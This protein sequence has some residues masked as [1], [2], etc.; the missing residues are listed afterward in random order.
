MLF[1][2]NNNIHVILRQVYVENSNQN[3]IFY[4]QNNYMVEIEDIFI[5]QSNYLNIFQVILGNSL[6]INNIQIS[7]GQNSRILQIL[8]T[9]DVNIQKIQ[10]NES[11]LI[12][13]IEINS[14]YI[15]NQKFLQ[16]QNEIRNLKI[17]NS[18]DVFLQ[19]DCGASSIYD[20]QFIQLNY[21]LNYCISLRT[22][23]LIMDNITVKNSQ[24]NSPGFI[25]IFMFNNCKIQNIYS[26][27]ND[28]QFI[29]LM[30]QNQGGFAYILNSK[31]INCNLQ[32][33]DYLIYL[34]SLD[35]IF[36]DQIQIKDNLFN[37]T[38]RSSALLIME[39]Q[40]ITLTNFQVKNNTNMMGAGGSIYVF[41]S[42]NITIKNSIFI[43]NKC[44]YFQGGALFISSS[45]FQSQLNIY[46]SIFLQN[47]ALVSTGGAISVQNTNII[48]KNTEIS[49]NRASI[50][51]GVYYEQVIPQFILDLKQVLKNNDNNNN[52]NTIQNNQ[53]HIYGNNFGSSLR[54]ISINI[55]SIQIPKESAIE[56]EMDNIKIS[57][58]KSGQIISFNKIQLLDEEDNPIFIP[59]IGESDFNKLTQD[60]Q[61]LIKQIIISLRWDQQNYQIQLQG[62]LQSQEFIN[63]G[64]N[65]NA[66]IMYQPQ[67]NMVLQI[68]SN[69][70]QQ[71]QDPKGNIVI[72]GGQFL[73]NI[74]ID[75][76]SCSTG[77]I[78]KDQ[79]NSIVCDQCPDG[80]YSLNT[81]DTDCQQCPIV[82]ISCY[83]SVINLKNGYWRESEMTDQIA[84]CQYNPI[85]CQSQSKNSKYGCIEGYVGTL[86]Q[87]C[88]IYGVVWKQRYSE[89]FKPGK[90]Y[91]CEENA[92]LIFV[93]NLIIFLLISTYIF[94]ILKNIISKLQSKLA[95]YYIQ[96]LDIIY[97]GS[98]LS[99]LD[100]PQIVSK[101]MTD[102]LQI[103]SLLI[104]FQ[105]NIPISFQLPV[106]FLGNS[107]QYAS[108]S[109]DCVFSKNKHLQPLWFY[110][111]L[112]S[113][114]LPLSLLIAYFTVGISYS[115]FKKN[116]IMLKYKTTAFLFIYFYFL[117]MV[118]T[119]LSRSIN[120]IQ[121]ANKA[122]LD[123]DIN[124]QCFD[125][126][127]HKPFIYYYS[128]PMLTIWLLVIPLC[129]LIKI[130]DFK[131]QQKSSIFS[132]CKYSFIFAGYKEKFYYWEF[133]KLIYKSLLIFI[134]ILLQQKPFLKVCLLNGLIFF[135]FYL[136][137]KAKPYQIQSFNNSLQKSTLLCSY[138]LNLSTIYQQVINENLIYQI[139]MI[140]L[141]IIP[142]LLFIHQ[143]L[144]GIVF[145]S[146]SS[147][148]N[149]RN[150]FQNIL[151]SLKC[152]F[153]T[154]FENIQ[155]QNKKKIKYLIKFKQVKNK[156]QK[157]IQ[158]LKSY[159]FYS[160]QTLQSHFNLQRCSP[161]QQ[162]S[163]I[164]QNTKLQLDQQ[165]NSQDNTKN[166]FFLKINSL[167]K[168][169]NKWSYYSRKTR[170]SPL[171]KIQNESNQG[172]ELTSAKLKYT[173]ED[174]I[175]SINATNENIN[176]NI[177]YN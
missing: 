175:C 34:I 101:I 13:L 97:L 113:F 39:S 105:V 112:W 3:N 167:N 165:T 53:A 170:Q 35:N 88:D 138:T 142:N 163:Q 118:I 1:T 136:I 174:E 21:T 28:L 10:V 110:Q 37:S 107:L 7:N 51:G 66:Q 20:L 145:I 162:T 94:Y 140:G 43:Q 158:Y 134:G 108:K 96:R 79:G 146:I 151:F 17:F 114:A 18:T 137:F 80:K 58:F 160:Q 132:V 157:L 41:E 52:N 106:Q 75:F 67:K 23:D 164:I 129:L 98:T 117:P 70:F 83:G 130:R 166:P 29:Y 102:H 63:G 32:Q 12:K 82:A 155:I 126:N 56:Q 69:T 152:N 42:V 143:I 150:L 159:D 27:S 103:L 147:D 141:L 172:M 116:K 46:D 85:S 59:K 31:F 78:Q 173:Q 93:Q 125:D 120:C 62:Q 48:M 44:L 144:L 16:I 133:G 87:S 90:C 86:C 149:D 148:K 15:Q 40:T 91:I 115:L 104:S 127:W 50:G 177:E 47:Q 54:K 156:I 84:Y 25:Q 119:L 57:L 8:G 123:I 71:L 171:C 92:L 135:Q 24:S 11:N 6:N 64:F 22:D 121:I 81:A 89:I 100:R 109:I 161:Q 169:R 5:E 131:N 9:V 124:I 2:L 33:N 68:V 128:I 55:K 95:G 77:E 49:Q 38:D 65:L 111:S 72:Q 153:P 176:Q 36:L 19:I 154:Q 99:K 60:I 76:V 26:F 14:F 4:L 73:Q 30:N 61:S 74:T 122:Y 168:M 45:N 139:V